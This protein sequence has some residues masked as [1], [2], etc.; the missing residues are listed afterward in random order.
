MMLMSRGTPP[1]WLNTTSSAAAS[2]S[3]A[4]RP[5]TLSQCATYAAVVPVGAQMILHADPLPKGAVGLAVEPVARLRLADEHERQQVPVVELEIREQP[6][7]LESGL[8]G[9]LRLVDDDRPLP[10]LVK[11][12]E[13]PVDPFENAVFV[14][15]LVVHPETERRQQQLGRRK[16]GLMMSTGW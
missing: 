13:L 1:E 14:P 9:R 16:P 12:V 4:F 6:D 8:P 3:G 11:L 10:R 7:L 15:A 5:A 2:K